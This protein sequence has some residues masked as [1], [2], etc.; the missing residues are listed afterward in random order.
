[1]RENIFLMFI[2]IMS[3]VFGFKIFSKSLC[4]IMDENVIIQYDEIFICD[5]YVI[6]YL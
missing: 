5:K 1:M 4:I 6:K 2:Y 3:L